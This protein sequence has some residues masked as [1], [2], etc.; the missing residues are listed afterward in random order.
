MPEC[1]QRVQLCSANEPTFNSTACKV[2]GTQALHSVFTQCLSVHATWHHLQKFY[3]ARGCPEAY[4]YE[5]L[6]PPATAL[7]LQHCQSV[8]STKTHHS[9]CES[10]CCSFSVCDELQQLP[11][12]AIN[13]HPESNET[14]ICLCVGAVPRRL[15]HHLLGAHMGRRPRLRGCRGRAQ[16]Q[17]GS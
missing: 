7:D 16:G 17:G 13:S 2:L 6:S 10:M 5:C 15:R 8:I 3:G 14:C 1:I 12:S 9:S 11:Y 4:C